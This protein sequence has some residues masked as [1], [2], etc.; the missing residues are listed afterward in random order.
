M[1]NNYNYDPNIAP[2][3]DTAF[4][5]SAQKYNYKEIYS[6]S[7]LTEQTAKTEIKKIPKAKVSNIFELNMA[8]THHFTFTIDGLTVNASMIHPTYKYSRFL[9]VKSLNFTSIAVESTKIQTGIFADFPIFHRKRMSTLTCTLND[10]DTHEYEHAVFKWFD[11]CIEDQKGFVATMDEI[12]RDARLVVYDTK[13]KAMKSF[14]FSIIPDGDITTSKNYET[15]SLKEFQFKAIIV[16][17]IY[18]QDEYEDG[19]VYGN[20]WGRGSLEDLHTSAELKNKNLR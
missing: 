15:A 10:L 17:P 6:K 7:G 14:N 8:L 4:A 11:G 5:Q 19:R 1:I 18:V 3:S 13:G 16:S 2:I 20:N 9:P 12:V